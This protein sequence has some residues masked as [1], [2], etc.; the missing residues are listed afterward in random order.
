MSRPMNQ[1]MLAEI[2]SILIQ[3][4]SRHDLQWIVDQLTAH[5]DGNRPAHV[6]T[7]DAATLAELD[8]R[9][10]QARDVVEQ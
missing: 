5:L 7:I 2:A 8:A 3:F 1:G 10:R 9:G 6:G 4:H